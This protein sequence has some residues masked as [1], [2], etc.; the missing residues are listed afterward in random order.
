MLSQPSYLHNRSPQ[1]SGKRENLTQGNIVS[2]VKNF[3]MEDLDSPQE[4][5]REYFDTEDVHNTGSQDDA[6]R[7]VDNE[8]K[9]SITLSD[10]MKKAGRPKGVSNESKAS[11]TATVTAD[12]ANKSAV[13][14]E[15]PKTSK[16]IIDDAISRC[17]QDDTPHDLQNPQAS[18][19]IEAQVSQPT[20]EIRGDQVPT[21]DHI[22]GGA[23]TEQIPAETLAL[24]GPFRK[25]QLRCHNT[26][27]P[28]ELHEFFG[29][30]VGE[31]KNSKKKAKSAVWRASKMAAKSWTTQLLD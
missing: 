20:P 5:A 2:T 14:V 29:I 31:D 13:R 15:L 22:Y 30:W 4:A 9:E 8:V 12:K 19:D 23:Q 25:I 1:R 27:T 26:P 21:V 28:E 11:K 6:L 18:Q 16:W 7:M 3:G 24:D 17:R 10:L